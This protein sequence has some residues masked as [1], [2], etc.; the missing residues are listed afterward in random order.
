MPKRI[1]DDA[2]KRLMI[3]A[4][5]N[6]ETAKRLEKAFSEEVNI[7]AELKEYISQLQEGKITF[8]DFVALPKGKK[9]IYRSVPSEQY[10]RI[11][12]LAVKHGVTQRFIQQQFFGRVLWKVEKSRE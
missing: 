10:E 4:T 6:E 1:R 9:N 7:V 8:C 2:H 3:S 5:T 11:A 12:S